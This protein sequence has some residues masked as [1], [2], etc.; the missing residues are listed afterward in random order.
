MT[1]TEIDNA[2]NECTRFLVRAKRAKDRIKRD[3]AERGEWA[4][5]SGRETAALRRASL[6]LTM[7]LAELRRGRQP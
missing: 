2:V 3:K 7:A 1:I 4:G 5:T 6:D